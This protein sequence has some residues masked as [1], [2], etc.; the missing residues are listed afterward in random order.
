MNE[1]QVQLIKSGVTLFA[2]KGYHSTSIQEIATKAGISKGAFYLYFESKE[3]F[4]GTTVEYF[5][6]QIIDRINKVSEKGLPPRENLA[7]QISVIIQYVYEYKP[8]IIMHLRENIAPGK[9]MDELIEKMNIDNFRWIRS[10]IE[11]IYGEKINDYL[12]DTIIQLEGLMNGY[13]KWIVIDHIKINKAEAG[14]FIVRRLDNIVEGMLADE[15]GPVV[16]VLPDYKLHLQKQL[17]VEQLTELL[18]TM[19]E[20]V[21][22]LSTSE[23]QKEKL[24]EVID[25]ILKKS[26]QQDKNKIIIQGLLTHLQGEEELIEDCEEISKLLEIDLLKSN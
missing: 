26:M 15:E 7:E 9:N 24:S 4:I 16:E 10:N 17:K 21:S 18:F 1:K 8:F 19:K 12:I 20:K 6:T 2:E 13:F 11:A 3:A 22:R 25:T 23:E 5:H 14:K